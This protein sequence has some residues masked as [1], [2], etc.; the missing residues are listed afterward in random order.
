MIAGLPA[1]DAAT[2]ERMAIGDQRE[3][4]TLLDRADALNARDDLM[5]YTKR[6]TP[7][8]IASW[9]HRGDGG[10]AGSGRAGRDPALDAD[11]APARRE[12]AFGIAAVSWLGIWAG[13]QRKRLSR[14]HTVGACRRF[15]A[16]RCET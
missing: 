1:I 9:V 2:L 11:T 16:R 14:L 8:Y 13:T 3:L 10:E 12:V 7:G 15:R 5:T 4:L 6:V